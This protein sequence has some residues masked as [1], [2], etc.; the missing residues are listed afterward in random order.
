[1]VLRS[2]V[3]PN[4]AQRQSVPYPTTPTSTDPS[5]PS[6]STHYSQEQM[7][8]PGEADLR[9][10]IHDLN[11][12]ESKTKDIGEEDAI[13]D[14]DDSDQD[15]PASKQGS[16][17]PQTSHGAVPKPLNVRQ[18]Q[19]LSPT[20]VPRT[21][22]PAK[23]A[24]QTSIPAILQVHKP[25]GTQPAPN[26]P[27]AEIPSGGEQ[28]SALQPDPNVAGASPSISRAN[29][30]PF[31]RN[32]TGEG[33]GL[34][35]PVQDGHSADWPDYG[36]ERE[37]NPFDG[38]DSNLS[39]AK[40]PYSV[41]PPPLIPLEEEHNY[42]PPPNP[43]T[44]R[45]Q[46]PSIP[47]PSETASSASLFDAPSTPPQSQHQQQRLSQIEEAKAKESVQQSRSKVA[48]QRN[49]VYQIRHIRWYDAS[50]NKNPRHAPILVQNANGPCPLLALVNA[51]VLTT[52]PEMVTA[53]IEA[54]RT[55]EQISLGLL[56]DAVFD[57][58]VSG[59][60]GTTA[61]V[62]PDVGDLYSFLIAL[63][64]GMNVNPRFI[65]P[66]DGERLSNL[67]GLDSS[68][69][70]ATRPFPLGCFEE[71]RE[72]RLYSTFAIPLIHGWLAEKHDAALAAFER[73]ANTYED[74]QN[75]QFR[76]EEI[77]QK[78]QM[79]TLSPED[80]AAF[81]DLTSIKQFLSSWPTQLTEYGLKVMQETLKPGQIAILFRNDHFSTLYK[82]PRSG[83]LMTLVTDMGYATHDEIIWESLV[84]LSGTRTEMYSGDFKSVSHDNPL[85]LGDDQGWTTVA[86]RNRRRADHGQ[87]QR[88]A[89]GHGTPPADSQAPTD[90]M[91]TTKGLVRSEQED[92]DLAL[93][94]QLQ[95]EEEER[96]RNQQAARR[97]EAELSEHFLSQDSAR[98][99]PR[100][101]I[102]P[103]RSNQGAPS[104]NP[105]PNGEN[106]PPPYEQAAAGR[107][108]HPPR[109]HPFSE[110]AP[111]R[112]S[113]YG[114]Q[115][116][117]TA[118]QNAMPPQPQGRR[119]QS[120]RRLEPVPSNPFD[121]GNRRYDPFASS[122]SVSD[123]REGCNVM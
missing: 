30:N 42:V 69:P 90:A 66:R 78:L 24:E 38:T 104:A 28:Q 91:P 117:Q 92:H 33:Q 88:Q 35:Y 95:E 73:S 101:A 32:R 74:A 81:M 58:L 68:D 123:R 9:H 27:S 17:P 40:S 31:I 3:D 119:Q 110:H 83:R 29:T 51:L 102:P 19:T 25:A 14:W 115:A 65:A 96:E 112:T 85:A 105:Q 11:L 72:M 36:S 98:Q 82:E 99:G 59:R 120:G 108:F 48:E 111:R 70:P 62:L 34:Q 86:S 87:T 39:S 16:H 116:A 94:M 77:E 7:G 113:L 107:P 53:L 89:S 64:T 61:K 44:G 80:E 13:S 20:N 118:Q 10:G 46:Y 2:S 63:H 1:M 37:A 122:N 22:P 4:S 52:A 21:E 75:I 5:V 55:R 26:P 50:C 100:P 71:T 49:E 57:E 114:Q 12:N 97:R 84:D 6:S 121:G 109:D 93:A 47:Q 67:A 103:R 54:L 15:E 8:A 79:G 43:N 45:T 60:R 56:L 76:E 23:S 41:H 18:S 106:A